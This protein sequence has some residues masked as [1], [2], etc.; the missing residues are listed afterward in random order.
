MT[1][2]FK[3]RFT[4]TETVT[5]EATTEGANAEEVADKLRNYF[6]GLVDNLIIHEIVEMDETPVTTEAKPTLR[7]VN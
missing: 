1:K 7:L 3:V 6:T 5:T 2:F 4:H